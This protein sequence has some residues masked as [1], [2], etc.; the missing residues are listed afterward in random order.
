MKNIQILQDLTKCDRNTKWAN[1]VGKNGAHGLAQP[2][3]AT[4]HESEKKNF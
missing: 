4:N 2:W 1:S 3:I